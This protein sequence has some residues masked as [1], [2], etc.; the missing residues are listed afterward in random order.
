MDSLPNYYLFVYGRHFTLLTDHKPLLSILGP[1]KGVP[2]LA[3]A[4]MQW[5]AL[6]L[7]SYQYEI[8]Y[9]KGETHGNA[10][11]LSLLPLSDACGPD[12]ISALSIMQLTWNNHSSFYVAPPFFHR[13]SLL[14]VPQT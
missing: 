5:W 9:R 8:R 12:D 13:V 2:P 7:A 14:S 1:Q 3:A 11:A 10:D 4:R 6:L